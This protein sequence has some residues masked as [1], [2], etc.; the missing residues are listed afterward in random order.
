[1]EIPRA[2]LEHGSLLS[3][4]CHTFLMD[5]ML[6]AKKRLKADEIHLKIFL[7]RSST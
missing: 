3:A 7:V 1:L 5:A 2:K 6:L 4:T